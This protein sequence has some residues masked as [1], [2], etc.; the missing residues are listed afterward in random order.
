LSDKTAAQTAGREA[1]RQ[2][3][4]FL[5]Q[6]GLRLIA[7]NWLCRQGELDLVM[8]DGDTVVFIEVRFRQHAAWGGAL[9][10]VDAR[11]RSKLAAAAQSFLQQQ[12][13]WSRHP[14]RFDVVA[15]KPG[16]DSPHLD[17]IKNAFD[18]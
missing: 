2:A 9:E 4:N 16:G 11:K 6:R 12:S 3:L 10:S 13:R 8:L 7:Q 1:E 5:Q 14:C 15:L 17:W 18:I